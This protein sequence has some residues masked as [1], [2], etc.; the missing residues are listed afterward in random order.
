MLN[1]NERPELTPAQELALRLY[2][3]LWLT[4]IDLEEARGAINEIIRRNLRRASTH[5]PTPLLQALTTALVVAYTR[6]FVMSRGSVTFADRA[7]PGS[8]LRV[9]SSDERA[10]H[11][12]LVQMRNREV[13]HSDADVTEVSLEVFPDGHGGISKVAR[14]PLSRPQLRQLLRMIEKLES[15]L[16]M[17]FE[18]LR[19]ELPNNV[20]L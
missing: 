7:V 9:F 11:E 1:P 8:I 20:W 6:P 10:F 3:R 2:R 14:D 18:A 16:Q 5:K 12:H 4:E 19:N 15:E 17:R 13:A